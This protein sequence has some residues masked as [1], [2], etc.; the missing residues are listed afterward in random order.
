VKKL[1]VA[2]CCAGLYTYG[3]MGCK[4]PHLHLPPSEKMSETMSFANK[5][6]VS[7]GSAA[8]RAWIVSPHRK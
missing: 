6:N 5:N 4:S 1:G 2:K 3:S 7:P 8:V